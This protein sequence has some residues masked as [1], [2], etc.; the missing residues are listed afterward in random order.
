MSYYGNSLATW[1]SDDSRKGCISSPSP[2][3][4]L[5]LALFLAL[6]WTLP[7]FAADLNPSLT[8]A[9]ASK[10]ETT[11]ATS[12]EEKLLSGSITVSEEFNDNVNESTSPQSD[13][14]TIIRPT[15]KLEYT[16]ERSS[17]SLNYEGDL[18]EYAFGQRQNEFL[19]TLNAKADLEVIKNLVFLETSD[20]NKMVFTDATLGES[21][22]SD[23]TST[24]V[25]QNILKGGIT[26]KPTS[27][28]R[29]PVSL[30]V[31]FTQTSYWDGSGINKSSQEVF[32]GIMHWVSPC[33]EVGGDI[34]G[35]HQQSSESELDRLS[36]STVLRYTY[37]QDS[38]FYG[39]VGLIKSL[40]EG[41]SNSLK[42][43]LSSGLTH[44]IGRTILNLDGQAGYVD[45]PSSTQDT[46]RSTLT[47]SIYHKFVRATL[48]AYSSFTDYSGQDTTNTHQ[49]AVGVKGEYE[50]TP[51]LRVIGSESYTTNST[52]AQTLDRLYGTY[53][54]R[55]EL[56]SD[57]TLSMWYRSKISSSPTTST[58]NYHVNML[59]LGLKK[60]F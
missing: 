39:R 34:R 58:N 48:G 25:N 6:I 53:E 20:S 11:S 31:N 21:T 35:L 43:L 41:G 56:P 1:S 29:T 10:P 47:A 2:I 26:I 55:Y 24:Q 52:S 36:A 15:L 22:S 42:P 8:A 40:I 49:L 13:L 16:G 17:A 14:V 45:N 23:S 5:T 38:F 37:A 60:T 4:L 3:W 32:L 33:L 12:T 30:G 59:G 9:G 19:N 50:L 51:R 54:I 57:Y 44:S 46:F 7:A 27:W 28:E 18:R